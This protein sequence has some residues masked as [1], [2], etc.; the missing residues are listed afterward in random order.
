METLVTLLSLVGYAALGSGF[1]V[2][3]WSTITWLDV[4]ANHQREVT[5][6]LRL[7]NNEVELMQ[8]KNRTGCPS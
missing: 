5:R 8:L 4:K 6:T 7:S 3:I 1:V 2:L